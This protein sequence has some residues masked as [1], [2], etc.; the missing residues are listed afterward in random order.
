MSWIKG[1]IDA[2]QRFFKHWIKDTQNVITTVLAVSYSYQIELNE[3]VF[4]QNTLF[5]VDVW[6]VG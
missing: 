1:T 3:I 2:L 6:Y 5:G 4:L